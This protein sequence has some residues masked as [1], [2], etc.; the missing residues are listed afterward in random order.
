MRF[1]QRTAWE[2]GENE[3]AQAAARRRAEGRELIDLTVSNPT[4]CGLAP[5]GADVLLPLGDPGALR[6]SPDP[7]G[8]T[9]ARRAV[10][11]YY[12]DLGARVEPGRICLTTSTSEAYSFLV[13]LLCD[14]GD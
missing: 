4:A 7:L 2:P 9:Q 6:Y 1:S 11:G 12:A 8:M 13:R 5:G 10:A 3:W 14:P